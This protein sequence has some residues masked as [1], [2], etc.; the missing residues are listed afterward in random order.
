MP[1]LGFQAHGGEGAG[2]TD[3]AVA[4]DCDQAAG[5][6]AGAHRRVVAGAHNVGEREQRAHRLVGVTAARAPDERAVGERNAHRTSVPS[7]NGTRTASPWP[8]SMPPT[9]QKPPLTQLVVC[10]RGSSGR[11]RRWRRTGRRRGRV[12]CGG[13]PPTQGAGSRPSALRPRRLLQASGAPLC[14]RSRRPP[15]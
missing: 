5:L 14:V 10:P 13:A 1:Y 15:R 3:R 6:D 4:D 12:T 2:E 9:A 11:C 8:P 7:A